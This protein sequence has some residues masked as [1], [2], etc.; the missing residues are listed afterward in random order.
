M[1]YPATVVP[2]YASIPS[3]D[4]LSARVR[5][6]ASRTRSK[7]GESVTW[8]P[9]ATTSTSAGCSAPS[10]VTIP[11]SVTRLMGVVTTS[12]FRRVNARYQVLDS[13]MRLHPISKFGVS[14]RRR[15]GSRTDRARC[16]RPIALIGARAAR[17]RVSPTTWN[18]RLLYWSARTARWRTQGA[19]R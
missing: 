3:L 11:P 17:V 19:V 10:E 1:G 15:P 5:P 16:A 8:N 18:S 9:V 7:N 2:L 14:L 12:M 4:H 6:A 13:R